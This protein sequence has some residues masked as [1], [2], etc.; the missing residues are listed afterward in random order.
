[1]HDAK[2]R[3]KLTDVSA[4]LLQGVSGALLR[5][6]TVLFKLTKVVF[7]LLTNVLLRLTKV[8]FRLIKA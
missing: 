5:L 4:L 8:L 7:R 2:W 6:T 1:M 3:Y